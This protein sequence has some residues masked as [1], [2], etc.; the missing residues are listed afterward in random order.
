MEEEG[1]GVGR[2]GELTSL[3]MVSEYTGANATS[4]IASKVE[5]KDGAEGG[6]DGEVEDEEDEGDFV[7][8]GV[9]REGKERASIVAP[10][11]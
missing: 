4:A 1:E 8:D 3:F 10:M 7:G 11:I 9:R 5:E 6:G 2:K